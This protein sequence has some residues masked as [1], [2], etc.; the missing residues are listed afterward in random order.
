MLQAVLFDAT[1]TLIAPREPIGEVY[2]REA[3]R[4][5][6]EISAWRL[7][8]AFRRVW[9]QGATLI[10]P[11]ASAAERP[12]LE[13]AAW[14]DIVRR[15][16]LAADSDR[17]LPD[18]E[19]S[20]TTLFAHYARAEAWALRGGT[21]EALE[22]LRRYGLRLGVVSNFDHRL[23]GILDGLGVREH[24]ASVVLAG[25]VGAEKPDPAIF[26]RALAELDVPASEALF[27]GDDAEK[28]LAGAQRAGLRALDVGSLA[29]LAELPDRLRTGFPSA[30]E[31]A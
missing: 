4:Q 19:E 22:A 6:V 15:T 12:A 30:Q 3:A 26:E 13:R 20:F 2:A 21:R 18:F 31:N 5:G 27:V 23:P 29:T 25:D 7:D 14:R 16:F 28:D 1:G 17:R 24:F 8:D 10:F 11:D 9:R